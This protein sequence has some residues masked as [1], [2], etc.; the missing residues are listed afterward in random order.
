MSDRS[1]S[2]TA[3][4]VLKRYAVVGQRLPR[5]EGR[6]QATGQASYAA[7]LVLPGMLYAR[8][9][10]SPYAH[11]R[12]KKIDTS[13]AERLPGVKAIVTAEDLP[14]SRPASFG[15][16]PLA[17]GKVRH[18]G[19]AVAAVAAISNDIAVEA[20]SLIKVE[21]EELPAVFDMEEALK[22][23]APLV[24]ETARGNIATH[25]AISRGDVDKGFREADYIVEERFV[26]RRV[27][28]TCME[29]QACLAS[30]D[31]SGRLTIQSTA[32][33]VFQA[34]LLFARSTGMPESKIRII[35]PLVVGGH[36]GSKNNPTP[37]FYIAA[38]LSRKTGL[39]VKIVNT[40]QEEFMVT[41]PRMPVIIDLKVGVKKDGTIT[42]KQTR[43]IGS[44]GAYYIPVVYAILL[45]AASRH[46]N[47]YRT[48]N[49]R[50][51]MTAVF[52]NDTPVGPMR[53]LGNPQGHFA[54]ESVMDMLAEKI[55][56]DPLEFRLKNALKKG[57][58][59]VHGW[60]FRSCGLSECLK[61]A[62]ARMAWK[63][64]KADRQPGRGIGIACGLHVSGRKDAGEFAG[65]AAFVKVND[66]GTVNLIS[67]AG[68]IGT[69]AATVLSQICAEELGVRLEDVSMSKADTDSVPYAS[70]PIASRVTLESGNAVRAAAADARNQLF[71]AVA[72]KLSVPLKDL[73]AREGKIYA[74]THPEK[75]MSIAE[76]A[77]AA[78][79]RRGG[80]PVLGRGVYVSPQPGT[81]PKTWYGDAA[82]AYSFA[83]DVAEVQV[84]RE[85]GE[86]K[87]LE[88]AAAQDLGK[89]INPML[90][91]GQI[92]GGLAMGMGY[93]LT[94][95]MV[96]E[97]GRVASTNFTD[98][99]IARTVDMPPV[100]P[101]LV[102]TNEPWGPYGA[103]GVGEV[104]AVPTAA[105]IGNAIYDAVGI[106]LKEL[107]F[108]P[109]KVL[110]AL[111]EKRERE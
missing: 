57:D 79:V 51:E 12:I 46:D 2:V 10:R 34:R 32:A 22:P 40:R 104:V 23:G 24:H 4:E 92:E 73:V 106:R 64:K 111:R 83:A 61:S 96:T 85:T 77:K 59:T 15:E 67:G 99:Q 14:K 58:V 38:L 45:T 103:K 39:P 80:G 29:T 27:T 9:V 33:G 94:E 37:A 11:A 87:V 13:K 109:E 7:D 5:V 90:A 18:V 84:D 16:V 108:T 68:D 21:Y 98:Y 30:F 110:K 48:E 20:A 19:E 101:I 36:F 81:D 28:H 65:A 93:A 3:R 107:P 86:V 41:R 89:T 63:K 88:L 91:E 1:T 42:A 69:G 55:G 74:G 52:T 43:A 70:P 72:E 62:A 26:T 17:A 95:E 100:H 6:Q 71:Q 50:T 49:T 25:A 60:E 35:Q 75:A 66:D 8:V 78:L 76:A 54:M 47:L 56:M 31:A 105:A 102:E 53:G 44:T 97:N 82:N